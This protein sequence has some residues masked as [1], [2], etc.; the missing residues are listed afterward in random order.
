MARFTPHTEA[1]IREMLEVIGVSSIDELFADVSPKFE[2]ELD[3]PLALSEHEVLREAE[4]LAGK[5]A[6]GLPVFLGAGAYDRITP[7]AVGQIISRGE[8]MTS[9][10]PY[11]PEVS[12]GHLQAIFE[13]QSVISELT[14][15]EVSNASVYDAASAVA[16]AALMTARLT[17][18]EP[19]VAASAGLN[20]RY[21]EV[22]ETYGVEVAG[23]P[24]EGGAT[25]FSSVPGD[26]SGVIVQSPNF[27]G[28]VED[29]RAASEAAHESG[30]LAV[31]VCDPVALAVL[32]PPGSLG[33][34]IAVGE[35]QPLGVPLMFGGPYAG[36]MATRQRFVRQLPGRIAGETVDREGR[37]AYVLTLR[38]REQDIRRARANS[39]ICTN[40]A[41]TALA[42]TIYAAL[43]GPEG[44]REVAELSI[45]KAHYLSGRLGE[46]GF[47]LRYPEAPFLWEFAV[48]M[49]DVKRANAALLERGIVGGLDLG[50]GAMLVA[51]TEK[52]TKEELD[53]FVEV[54]ANAG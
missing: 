43:M 49:P 29:V 13:F 18:R 2:G 53:A 16:E 21:R 7:A 50:D 52:R 25:D 19:K 20:P 23:L 11:Q 15:L 37:L 45:S 1:D 5:N 54:V 6:A 47:A 22:L 31:A 30:A 26:V 3:L 17:G 38:A 10:T 12:Q 27:F 4:R 39:N 46:A 33:A 8:F 9:Y 40:Q 24:F 34:D 32:E 41:L 48:E 36:Y 42:A 44:L 14:G 28:I 35:T 51:V